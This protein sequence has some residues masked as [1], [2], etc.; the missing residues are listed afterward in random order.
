MNQPT[1]NMQHRHKE[2]CDD[3]M[4]IKKW[5]E[6]ECDVDTRYNGKTKD[7]VNKLDGEWRVNKDKKAG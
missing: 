7:W 3:A 5:C 1:T 4:R 6:V 2:D